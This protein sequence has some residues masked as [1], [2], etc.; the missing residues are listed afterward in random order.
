MDERPLIIFHGWSDHA[1]SFIRLAG[2]IEKRLKRKSQLIDLADYV[3]MDDA[4]TYN[5]IVTAM[6]RAWK[7]EGL[8]E[9]PGSVDVIVH[10]TGG[11]VIRDWLVRN[12][13]PDDA[14]IKHLVMLAPANF[15]SPLAH[16]GRAFYGRVLKGFSG[17]HLFQVGSKL[18]KGLE[19]ASPYTWQL[20]MKDRFSDRSYYEPGRVL[21]TVLVGNTGFQGI[22][23]AANEV[24]SDGTVRIACANMNCAHVEADFYTDPLHPTYKMQKSCGI[25]AFGVLNDENHSTIVGKNNGPRNPATLESIIRGLTVSDHAFV[26]WCQTLH[27]MTLQSERGHPIPLFQN[28]VMSV[29]DQFKMRVG[30]YFMEFYQDK[31][32]DWFNQRFHEKIIQTVHAYE[33]DKSFRSFNINCNEYDTLAKRSWE[34]MSISLTA[35]PALERRGNLVGYRTYTDV[36]IGSI[37]LNK[38]EAQR[39]FVPNRTLLF[40]IKLRREQAS[41][42]FEMKELV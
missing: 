1:K 12:Y 33:D 14:P 34:T 26:E 15:G 27:E 5:D 25:T 17:R 30:D 20:A 8:P 42:V 35:C 13:E 3:T 18:L 9:T 32:N 28:I 39:W 6:A 24:G 2:L 31:N 21:C 4:V 11:L 36:D 7:R 10:S 23:A 38:E 29:D 41:E 22:S 16:K 40:N 37:A 19:L